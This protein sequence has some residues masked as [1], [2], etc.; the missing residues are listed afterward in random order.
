MESQRRA[1]RVAV[2]VSTELDCFREMLRGIHAHA[3]QI[4]AWHLDV[5]SPSDDF[6]DF[7]RGAK[8][9]G[10]LISSVYEDGEQAE[11]LRLCKHTVAF[12]SQYR[13]GQKLVNLVEVDADNE[14][15]GRTAAKYFLAKGFTSFL[16]IA[17]NA[18]WSEGRERGFRE[19][20]E[21]A[22]YK[23][24]VYAE[25]SMQHR[26]RAW[27]RPRFGLAVD[28]E[29][30]QIVDSQP[31]PMAVLGCNDMRG[32]AVL[33]L[34]LS[35]GWRVPEDIAVL[36]VDND[37]LECELAHPPLSS[38]AIPWRTL[39]HE[40]SRLL[41]TLMDE[42]PSA[43]PRGGRQTSA[44]N[45]SRETAEPGF[46][47]IAPLGVIE[48]QSTD[49]VAI[50]DP[51]VAAAIRFIREHAHRRIGVTD[52]LAVVPIAR[53]AL[54]KR[55]REQ[56]AR[57][58]LEEIRRVRVDRAKQLLAQSELSMPQVAE[59]CGFATAAW[60]SSAFRALVGETPSAYRARHWAG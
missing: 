24:T 37:S 47:S 21:A 42:K 26:P 3:V 29:L 58:P 15:V 57:S 27:G 40:A 19:G 10:L 39:G 23:L 33:E 25:R 46:Y 52:V 12:G 41:E 30:V 49:V 1:R 11:A 36:G 31:K 13:R 34:C 35:R 60:F 44:P 4:G 6:I 20:V 8:P 7:I 17:T 43:K 16:F 32:R 50:Q 18:G 9:D 59:R 5:L 53:R 14:E 28:D 45:A 55:F 48:R 54:E 38:V 56:L 22:G 2:V 51:D